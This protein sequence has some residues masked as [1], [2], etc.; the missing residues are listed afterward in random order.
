M[1]AAQLKAL[2]K[3]QNTAYFE[4]THSLLRAHVRKDHIWNVSYNEKLF[5]GNSLITYYLMKA[6]WQARNINGISLIKMSVGD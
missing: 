2:P 1:N 4:H 6:Q 5:K 3:A